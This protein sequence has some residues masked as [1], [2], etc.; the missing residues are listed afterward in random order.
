M[1]FHSIGSRLLFLFLL[2]GIL[3]LASLGYLTL[4]QNELAML[5]ETQA[6]LMRLADKKALEVKRYLAARTENA[7]VLARS[8]L[9]GDGL[10]TLL[11]AYAQRLKNPAPYAR[12]NADFRRGVSA[13]V[14]E[15]GWFYDVFMI[16]P[17]GEIVFSYLHEAD[18]ATNLIDGPYRGSPLALAFRE[19]R[20]TLESS[21][22]DFEHYPPSAASGAFITVPIIRDNAFIGAV[23]FQ[24]NTESIY[25]VAMD[26]IGLGSTGETQFAKP[27]DAGKALLTTPLKF[28]AQAAMRRQI[29]LAEENDSPMR[30]AMQGE[31]GAGIKM[32]YRGKRVIAAWHYL[33]ELRWGMVLKIDVEEALE[34]IQKQQRLLLGVLSALLLFVTGIAYF[35]G[36]QLLLPLRD[37][38]QTADQIAR[39]DLIRR[40][41]DSGSDEIG[42][43]GRTFNQMAV[44]LQALYASLEERVAERTQELHATNEQLN[45]EVNER[46]HSEHQL[47]LSNEELAVYKRFV[48]STD[49]GMGMALLDGKVL[50]ANPS[51]IRMLDIDGSDLS[52]Y[53]FTGFY[54]QHDL[55]R[56]TKQVLPEVMRTG[57]W[58]GE[59]SL[60][61]A[62]GRAML[63]TQELFLLHD[64]NGEPYALANVIVDISERNRAERLLMRHNAV[65][66]TAQDGFWVTDG[67]GFILE[68]NE[69]YARIS[70]YTVEELVGM[71]VSQLEAKESGLEEVQ[72][73]IERT[74]AQG[75]DSFETLHRHKDGHLIDIDMSTTY[76]ADTDE[77]FT[78][79]CDIS[80]RKQAERELRHSQDMLNEAQ[81]MGKLGAWELDLM[82]GALRWSDEIFR[83]F[84]LDSARFQP[85]YESFL[86]VIHPDDRERVNTAYTD[87]LQD[88]LPYDVE[89]RLLMPD[90]R[91]KWVRE[92]CSSEFDEEG[93]PLRSIGA[94]QDITEQKQAEYTLRVAATAFETHEGIMI[95]DV[96]GNIL[97]VNHAFQE[98]TGYTFDEVKGRNPRLLSSGRHNR[99]F[100]A[101]IWQELLASGTWSG[102]IWDRRKN[103][104]IYPKWL[105]I[106]AVRDGGGQTSEYVAIF[107]DITAR[108]QA[109]EEIRSLAFYDALT[110]LP[111]RRLLLDRFRLAL[112]MSARSH[113]YGGLL[114]LDMDRFKT[115]NDTLGHDYGDDMLVEV[116]RRIQSCVREVD[117]VARLGGDE[118]VVLL[119][120]LGPNPAE[121]TQRIAL[122]AEKIRVLLAQPYQLKGHEHHSSPSIGVVLYLGN[123]KGVDELLKHADMAMYQAKGSGRNAVRFYDPR[124]QQEV[125]MRVAMESDLRKAVAQGQLQLYYQVQVDEEGR[126]TGAEALIRWTHPHRGMVSPAQFIPVA[127]EGLLIL[128]IGQWVL[129]TACCQ[130]AEWTDKDTLR[131]LSLAVNVS[132]QQFRLPDFVER[133]DST[134]RRH[135]IVP[136]RLKLELTESVVLSDVADVI[137]KMR[138]L[139]VL[140]VRLS[141]D[142]FGTGYS[143]LSY[144]KALPLDQIKIDQSF[145][146]D[147][148]TDPNDAV[149]VETIIGMAKNFGL[150]VIAE[151][152]ETEEQKLFLKRHGCL[153]YQGY[154]FGKPVPAEQFEALLARLP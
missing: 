89:H 101:A 1:T 17:Q 141:L 84:E 62:A 66:K 134:L 32:D 34:P 74:V 47:K 41:T 82:G 117:T 115:L 92:H 9:A 27:G 60:H 76:M 104:E 126:P 72:A 77:F 75:H 46:M 152:V 130:L 20:M 35:F 140:G 114:F 5:N 33:P 99:E 88:K 146:R 6:R 96:Q 149:M 153:S 110:H 61:D 127:E 8:E 11:S 105:T 59:L 144:L 102:E 86:N 23:A 52:R 45:E 19:T 112:S 63:T 129:D 109:E 38:A 81:R 40:V 100:Y 42:Q 151:G 98:I 116:S 128:E 21:V 111:N 132:A 10:R 122:V 118:F 48:D 28:D 36:R 14:D 139:K 16:S 145:V 31:R 94:V 24:L 147:I 103:G 3:P 83:I 120:E 67:R 133:V 97:R 79:C 91:I 26:S 70:G 56:L 142:D 137:A 138:E 58:F 57:H 87:S 51:L 124:M 29:D 37:L 148:V 2:V 30:H 43:L 108:K 85:S 80:G 65:L 53:N 4:S 73:H 69:A 54:P 154:L 135:G 12:M 68:V 15:T 18:F 121:A 131:H 93:R 107:S 49:N 7:R 136:E 113:S 25:R 64:S 50:Y 22:S 125:E 13:Y 95:T 78:F 143:S 106:T 123:E 90:G 119:E 39:G 55:E 150:D 44:K 71:H